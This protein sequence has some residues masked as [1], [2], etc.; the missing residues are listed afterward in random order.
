MR[1]NELKQL[2]EFAIK[3]N[4]PVLVSGAPG[5]G[6]TEI[7]KQVVA[8]MGCDLIISHPVVSDPTDYKGLPF[9][10]GGTEAEFLPFGELN[11]LIKAEKKTVF[12]I[13]DLGQ[14]APSVQAAVMQLVLGREIN[15]KKISDNIIFFAA[16]NRR[17]DKAGVAGILE[18]LKSRF[19]TI[20]ELTPTVD[21][22]CEWANEEGLPIELVSFIRFRPELLFDFEAQVGMKNSSTPRTVTAVGRLMMKGLPAS[23]E[24]EVFAGAAGEGFAVEFV[25]YKKIMSKI[26]SV[27][28]IITDP[29]S[30]K[31]PTELSELYA[32]V[33][34]LVTK[35]T[36]KNIDNIVEWLQGTPME[37]QVFFF[38]DACARQ[39]KLKTEKSVKAWAAKAF[40]HIFE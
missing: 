30:V 16:T 13:D 3:N 32:T 36:M 19:S 39:P 29:K 12:F 23:L 14:A 24:R 34:C 4:E 8:N 25:N 22:W 28:K 31:V 17:E 33:A 35:A 20:I 21:D 6:K 27:D 10:T 9:Y 18:P 2:L 1:A 38:K 7:V 26:T 15:G 11:K 40:K 5:I 37:M